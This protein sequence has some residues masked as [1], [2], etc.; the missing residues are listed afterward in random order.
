[1]KKG[2]SRRLAATAAISSVMLL[3]AAPS[4]ALAGVGDCTQG[5]VG[6]AAPTKPTWY[7]GYIDCMGQDTDACI[8]GRPI[9]QDPFGFASCMIW[10]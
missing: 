7:T 3:V 4:P 9:D 1:M 2:I 8:N 6:G 5:F 10:S